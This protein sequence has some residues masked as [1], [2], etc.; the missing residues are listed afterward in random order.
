MKGGDILA[1][2]PALIEVMLQERQDE[3]INPIGWL[4]ADPLRKT[5]F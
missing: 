3:I 2:K 5:G 4:Q 1:E